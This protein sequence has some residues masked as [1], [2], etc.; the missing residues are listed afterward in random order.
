MAVAEG[1]LI[2]NYLYLFISLY[3]TAQGLAHRVATM[4]EVKVRSDKAYIPHKTHGP[5]VLGLWD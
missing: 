4:V 3:L 1:T 2:I 5:F